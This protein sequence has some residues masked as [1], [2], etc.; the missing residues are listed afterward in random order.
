MVYGIRCS[1]VLCSYILLHKGIYIRVGRMNQNM[2]SLI[3]TVLVVLTIKL[4][5]PKPYSYENEFTEG[6]GF[7]Q[8]IVPII[9]FAIWFYMIC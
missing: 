7:I 5:F 4:L 9:V 1:N 2:H 3:A 8:V 6:I